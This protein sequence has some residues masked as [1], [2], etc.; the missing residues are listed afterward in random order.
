[1][2][3]VMGDNEVERLRALTLDL[4]GA[5]QQ[6]MSYANIY[7]EHYEADGEVDEASLRWALDQLV[8]S[9]E[10]QR[11]CGDGADEY[12]W[13]QPQEAESLADKVRRLEAEN[14]KIRGWCEGF[15]V[16]S[17]ELAVKLERSEARL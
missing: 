10:V 15:E 13:V 4:L 17:I 5:K 12:R 7:W 9:G 14:A 1:M 16:H 2:V 11:V 6:A 3:L 8:D